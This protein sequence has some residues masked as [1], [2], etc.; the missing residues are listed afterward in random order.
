MKTRRVKAL[1]KKGL[2][3]LIQA[4]EPPAQLAAR[5]MRQ[6][7]LVEL[8][9]AHQRIDERQTGG[10]TIAHRNRRRPIERADRRGFEP[11]Q[12]VV[13]AHDLSPVGLCRA[14]RFTVHG[15][16]RRLNDIRPDPPARE[17]AF[18]QRGAFGDLGMAPQ[19][20][21]LILEKNQLSGRTASCRAPRIVQEHHRQQA[22]A[23]VR[24]LPFFDPERKRS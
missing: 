17:G 18:D 24:K 19:C 16:N 20:P 2:R 3:R 23:T 11:K 21:V 6:R 10:R 14:R 7:I 15:R 4:S 9:T 22:D 5:R 8:A 12:D 1:S 13:E